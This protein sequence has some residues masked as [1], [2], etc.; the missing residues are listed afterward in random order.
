MEKS[1]F[2]LSPAL[3]D[4]ARL[5]TVFVLN[6]RGQLGQNNYVDNGRKRLFFQAEEGNWTYHID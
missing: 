6:G 2:E 1:R 4:A 5:H 3:N